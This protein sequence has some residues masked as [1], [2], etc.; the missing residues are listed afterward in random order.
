MSLL[1][2]SGF[3]RLDAFSKPR[4][5]LRSQSVVGGLITLIA[6][7]CAT[8]LFIAQVFI[9][10]RGTPQHFLHVSQSQ[11]HHLLPT[12]HPFEQK[13]MEQRKPKLA[14]KFRVTFPLLDC[15]KLDVAQDNASFRNGD[16]DKLY[17]HKVI[18]FRQATPLEFTTALGGGSTLGLNR[19]NSCTLEGNIQAP[20]V[21]GNVAITLTKHTWAEASSFLMVQASKMKP[22]S[23]DEPQP[24][25]PAL[26]SPYNISH[27][28]HSFQFGRLP[29]GVVSPLQDHGHYIQEG[30]NLEHVNVKLIPTLQ[31]S[32]FGGSQFSGLFQPSVADHSVRQATLVMQGIMPGLSVTYDITPLAVRQTLG[33]EH[34]LVFLSSLMSIVGGVF[35]SVSLI[36]NCLVHAT[37]AAV[38]KKI[39]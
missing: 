21:A 39:D 35:V 3:Q 13:L 34:I 19:Q 12:T 10:I 18:F 16:L 6:S 9:Y 8:L 37:A 2:S 11:P 5:D 28:I 26:V 4:Q 33:R 38:S 29:P 31:S 27:Y 24:Q 17:G 25:Q 30:L 32:V 20:L 1:S 23:K 14:I 22:S 15:D 36:T 7:T